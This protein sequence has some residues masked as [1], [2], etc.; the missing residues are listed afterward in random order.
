[1]KRPPAGN[2]SLI[3][4]LTAAVSHAR[5]GRVRSGYFGSAHTL[6][7]KKPAEGTPSPWL[8]RLQ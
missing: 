5:E 8:K 2:D 6:S 1:M 7:S 4:S 3:V